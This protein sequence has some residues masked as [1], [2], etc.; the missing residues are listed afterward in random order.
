MRNVEMLDQLTT[1]AADLKKQLMSKTGD[2]VD[3]LL[4]QYLRTSELH[5]EYTVKVLSRSRDEYKDAVSTL[6]KGVEA[7]R[8]SEQKTKDLVK[9]LDQITK[10]LDIAEDLVRRVF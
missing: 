10:G 7:L 6:Q 4:E 8:A 2:I 9:I 5:A 3:D 1:L